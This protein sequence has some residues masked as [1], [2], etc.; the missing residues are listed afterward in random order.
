MTE[1]R[2]NYTSEKIGQH[3]GIEISDNQTKQP[4]DVD[5]IE[6]TDNYS[7]TKDNVK[8]IVELLNEL[9]EEKEI[10]E[11][12]IK[13]ATNE[14][15]KLMSEIN[16]LTDT[17]H[18]CCKEIREENKELKQTIESLK[19]EIAELRESENDNYKVTDGL[20]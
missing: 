5:Y 17:C 9:H 2:F 15:D 13:S 14:I 18:D 3:W 11:V 1:K 10:L 4:F 7:Q 20:W 6:I 8:F 16:T 19:M 12:Q